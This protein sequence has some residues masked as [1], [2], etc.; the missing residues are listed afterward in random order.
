MEQ[1][2][3]NEG[4]DTPDP[5]G[6]RRRVRKPASS[7]L[8]G[9]LLPTSQNVLWPQWGRGSVAGGLSSGA[10]PK[11][12]G[13]G[14]ILFNGGHYN[15]S[16]LNPAIRVARAR[17]R[18]WGYRQNRTCDL[19]NFK[20]AILRNFKPALTPKDKPGDA[21]SAPPG[22]TASSK[23]GRTGEDAP[24][25]AACSTICA[26]SAGQKRGPCPFCA[27]AYSV[28]RPSCL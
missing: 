1:P 24:P 11:R 19:G 26:N 20:P 4:C 10:S 6:N 9:F 23:L 16:V 15:C 18:F 3:Y 5:G 21:F 25:A 8:V 17:S 14:V 13:T 7:H 2:C 27:A 22:L 12:A 28:V